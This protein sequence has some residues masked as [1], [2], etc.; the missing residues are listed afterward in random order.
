MILIGLTGLAQSG[1]DTV[2]DYL[3]SRHGF[4][5]KSFADPLKQV[6]RDM[7]PILGY[8]ITAPG[9]LI[10]V[11]QALERFGETAVKNTYPRYRK[12][13]QMLGTEGIR[14]IDPE[15]WINAAAQTLEESGRYVFTDV[16]FPNEADFIGSNRGTLWQVERHLATKANTDQHSSET[17]AGRM[18]EDFLIYNNGSMDKLYNE[19]EYALGRTEW[20]KLALW[21]AFA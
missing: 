9:F 6:L 16:R 15:F 8:D 7:D 21:K 12:Y 4:E 2:A 3:V 18:H 10:T 19:I 14:K 5:K 11:T 17:W 1:K 20:Q 13:L